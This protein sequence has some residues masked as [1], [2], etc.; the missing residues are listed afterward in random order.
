MRRVSV[1]N[2]L[3]MGVAIVLLVGCG[4]QEAIRT[5]S[6]A[7]SAQLPTTPPSASP[8]VSLSVRPSASPSASPSDG[9]SPSQEPTETP[10]A[11]PSRTPAP[12]VEALTAAEARWKAKSL[13]S[14][15]F[16]YEPGCFC[17]RTKLIMTVVDSAVTSVKVAPGQSADPY[18]AN[19][20]PTLAEA[21]TMETL[22]AQLRKAYGDK[23]AA[24]VEASYDP[25]FGFPTSVFVDWDTMMADEETRYAVS[26]FAAAPGVD[27]VGTWRPQKDTGAFITF[28]KDGTYTGSDGCNGA[29]GTWSTASGKLVVTTGMHTEIGCD[30][31]PVDEWIAKAD[32][33]TIAADTITIV[34]GTSTQVLTRTR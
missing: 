30:N 13:T 21:A 20:M 16:T 4:D 32:S 23:P 33:V 9:P 11:S 29:S 5:G 18:I 31:Q 26:G 34:T 25:E 1:L 12:G 3:V 6:A 10:S 27:V 15:S 24:V 7:S 14:Y 2:A 28:A 17:P 19:Y 8:S 22:F